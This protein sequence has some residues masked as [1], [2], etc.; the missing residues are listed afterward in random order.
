MILKK[1]T[2]YSRG[3]VRPKLKLSQRI[4]FVLDSEQISY[5]EIK[6]TDL[7][8]NIQVDIKYKKKIYTWKQKIDVIDYPYIH[9]AFR[10]FVKR[11][12]RGG[13]YDA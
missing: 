7:I 2:K 4:R 5:A 9:I 6:I 1:H 10:E 11:V 13:Y 3:S 8:D 12:K